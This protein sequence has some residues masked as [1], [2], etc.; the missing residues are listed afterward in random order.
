MPSDRT[1]LTP[2][3]TAAELLDM[4]YLDMRCHL[5]ETA[6]AFDRI[7]RAEGGT[8]AFNDPRVAKLRKALKILEEDELERAERFLDLFSTGL[9]GDQ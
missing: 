3:K 7:Q 2:P 4:Y 8:E 5:L 9:E 6:A 1:P